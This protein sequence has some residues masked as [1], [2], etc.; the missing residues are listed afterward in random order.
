MPIRLLLLLISAV[1][2]IAA[3]GDDDDEDSSPA[4]PPAVSEQ[5]RAA[6]EEALTGYFGGDTAAEV[7]AWMTAGHQA[8]IAGRGEVGN[9]GEP[10]DKDCESDIKRATDEG[11]FSLEPS[12]PDVEEVAIT[13]GLAAARVAG[14]QDEAY[15]VFLVRSDGKWLVHGEQQPPPNYEDLA[16]QVEG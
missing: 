2:L 14:V 3:C 1:F 15:P 8:Q 13:G 6:V 9:P 16:A 12:Q 7:C 11:K 4:T 5:D 10:A